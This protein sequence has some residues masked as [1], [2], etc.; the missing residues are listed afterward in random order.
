MEYKVN[1]EDERDKFAYA[2]GV[3]YA[4]SLKEGGLDSL[5]KS[6][7]IAAMNDIEQ[8]KEQLLT[9]QECQTTIQNKLVELE[10]KKNAVFM[11]EGQKFLDEN[12]S[13]PGVK[14]TDSGL[15][16]EVLVAGDG[17]KPSPNDTV[18]VHYHGTLPD[19]TVFESS[20][21]RGRPAEFLL[22]RMIPGWVEAL[23]MMPVGSK[24]KLVI[25][26]DLAYGAN[27]NGPIKP[28]STL[29]FELELLDI[30]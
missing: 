19:G 9:D 26:Q 5:S 4:K 13:K 18:R 24:Y 2:L 8:G 6:A 3:S 10:E 22:S 28:Y 21:E 17:P 23:Q 30:L 11:E 15:Q 1:L 7:F 27:G 14:V 25:P 16:Y 20:V 12:A 29:V